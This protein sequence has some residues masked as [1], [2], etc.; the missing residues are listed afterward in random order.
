M[1]FPAVPDV[2]VITANPLVPA[3]ALTAGPSTVFVISITAL[4][5]PVLTAVKSLEAC[6]FIAAVVLAATV[7]AVS[8]V[9]MLTLI[10]VLPA[11][12]GSF[13]APLTLYHT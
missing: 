2:V 12:L 3:S 13:P 5:P 7:L 9:T 4:G 8:F 11:I 6:A 1:I 10:P